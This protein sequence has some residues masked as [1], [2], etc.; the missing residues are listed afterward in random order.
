DIPISGTVFS[1]HYQ[2]DRQLGRAGADP[3]AISDAQGLGGWT[4]SVHHAL[5]S[6]VITQFCIDGSCTPWGLQPKPLFLGDGQMRSAASVPTP[7]RLN[8]N[9]YLASED[10]G[11]IYVFDGA[12]GRHLQTLLPLTGAI[13]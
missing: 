13:L 11:A 4:L 9:V 6:Q 12:S 1:L 8:G 2:S 10:G 5:N 7:V 3:V